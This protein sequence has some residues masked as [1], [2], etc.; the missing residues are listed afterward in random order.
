[1]FKVS[2][3]FFPDFPAVN[4]VIQFDCPEDADTYIHRAGR[5]ARFVLV[6]LTDATNLLISFFSNIRQS[7]YKTTKL[8]KTKKKQK[9]NERKKIK[10]T[11]FSNY[12]C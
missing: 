12:T 10:E 1:M 6:M 4:W 3:V 8:K 5:T 2:F 7:S 11:Y 9:K